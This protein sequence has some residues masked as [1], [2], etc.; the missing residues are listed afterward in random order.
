M[1]FKYLAVLAL[2][3][4]PVLTHAGS[5]VQPEV[6][7][8]LKKIERQTGNYLGYLRQAH[9]IYDVSVKGGTSGSTYG[10]GVTLPAKSTILRGW[11]TILTRFNGSGGTVALKCEDSANLL[12]A[13]DLTISNYTDG[14]VIR[15]I[16]QDAATNIIRGTT[17]AAPCEISAT[18]ATKT[19]DAGKALIFLEY[20]VSQ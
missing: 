7:S 20:F 2:L 4:S 10:L 18:I 17:I 13:T 12:A 16:P 6:D 1:N 8:R 14:T 3:I 19:Q 11:L 9:A 5:P 15:L